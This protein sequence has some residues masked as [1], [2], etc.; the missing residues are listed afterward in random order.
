[1][2]PREHEDGMRP[3]P[4][5][6]A[7]EKADGFAAVM[8]LLKNHSPEERS[9]L[10]DQADEVV[11]GHEAYALGQEYLG[12]GNYE[13]ARRWL[14]MAAGHHIPGAAEVLKEISLR[15]TL[16]EFAGLAAFGVDQGA[17]DAV[18]CGTIPSPSAMRVV[19]G[20]HRFTG[21]QPWAPVTENL[22]AR[23]AAAAR[24]QAH[25]IIAQARREADA[26][27]AEARQEADRTATACAETVLEAEQDRAEAAQLLAQVRQQAE[28]VM[29]ASAEIMLQSMRNRRKV[30]EVLAEARSI[31]SEILDIDDRVR[32]RVREMLV[33]AQEEALQIID[34][35]HGGAVQVHGK[36]L[37]QVGGPSRGELGWDFVQHMEEVFTLLIHT[38][39]GRPVDDLGR[40]TVDRSA[41]RLPVPT[42][43]GRSAPARLSQVSLPGTI[44]LFMEGVNYS[45]NIRWFR[46]AQERDGQDGAGPDS[47]SGSWRVLS[48]GTTTCAA[49]FERAERACGDVTGVVRQDTGPVL[50]IGV[51]KTGDGSDDD[52]ETGVEEV[53]NS[54]S[55]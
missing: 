38:P 18:P 21:D 32:R 51:M 31:R 12:R 19:D 13:A 27:L 6:S 29:V 35:A 17:G 5:L 39:S 20:T 23:M 43:P 16:D 10:Q 45:T 49:A 44:V 4:T 24:E 2:T 7:A 15:Q 22:Y 28:R 11:L 26:I 8:K 14:R 25:R 40:D 37:R 30:A 9:R 48:A 54:A 53:E 46:E 3:E 33:K 1:M 36:A 34:E 42:R 41:H 47:W 50:A 55:R 52:A